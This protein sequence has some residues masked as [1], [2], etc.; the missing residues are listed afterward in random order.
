LKWEEEN[1]VLYNYLARHVQSLS[2]WLEPSPPAGKKNYVYSSSNHVFNA[3]LK[4]LSREIFEPV[5]WAVW[6]YLG[7]NVN[8]LWFFNFNDDP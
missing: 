5:F 4:E 1:V 3:R 8:R 2:S 6:M 7:P